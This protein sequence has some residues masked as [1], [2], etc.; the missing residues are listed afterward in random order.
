MWGEL[1]F[2]KATY[3]WRSIAASLIPSNVEFEH[4]KQIL[5]TFE[6]DVPMLGAFL[7]RLNLNEPLLYR[8]TLDEIKPQFFY[9]L[10]TQ[11]L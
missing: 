2:R 7:N 10:A 5:L 1:F 8:C 11:T 9:H 4:A 6:L 3:Y